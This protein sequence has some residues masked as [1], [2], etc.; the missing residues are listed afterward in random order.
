MDARAYGLE[1]PHCGAVSHCVTFSSHVSPPHLSRLWRPGRTQDEE[2]RADGQS[3]AASINMNWRDWAALVRRRPIHSFIITS[4]QH[5]RAPVFRSVILPVSTV[6]QTETKLQKKVDLCIIRTPD[7]PG[8]F[9]VKKVRIIFEVLRYL[10]VISRLL[11][12][13]C[14]LSA[15]PSIVDLLQMEHPKIY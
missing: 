14:L 11:L 4:K 7:F 9:M 8:N 6:V 1:R 3:N 2:R 13:R 12:H 5:H 10:K 15:D